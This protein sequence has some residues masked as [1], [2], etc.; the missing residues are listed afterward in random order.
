MGGHQ[1][2]APIVGMKATPD[3]RGYWLVASDG[4]IFKFGDAV[5]QGSGFGRLA[6]VVKIF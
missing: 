3:A 5:S 2:N 1:L 4:E 6:N